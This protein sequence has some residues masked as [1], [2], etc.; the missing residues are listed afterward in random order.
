MGQRLDALRVDRLQ[1]L[2]QVE[3]AVQFGLRVGAL[4]RGQ[5]DSGQPGYAGH[6][7][8]VER[9]GEFEIR[10]TEGRGGPGQYAYAQ[11]VTKL[12]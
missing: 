3:D 11:P 7:F 4:F 6:I 1:P 10:I 2:D 8:V 5:F 12:E 9:H